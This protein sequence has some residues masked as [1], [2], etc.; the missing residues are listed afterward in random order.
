M[1][2]YRSRGCSGINVIMCINFSRDLILD[3]E[4]WIIGL[5]GVMVYGSYPG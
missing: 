2:D 3:E 4:P 1:A 5:S